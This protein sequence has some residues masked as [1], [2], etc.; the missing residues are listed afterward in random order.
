VFEFRHG[1]DSAEANRMN[2]PSKQAPMCTHPLN[3]PEKVKLKMAK[4]ELSPRGSDVI[5]D[6][7]CGPGRYT[8]KLAGLAHKIVGVDLSVEA[9]RLAKQIC[10]L[11]G[12][13]DR[14]DFVV[15][16]ATKLPFRNASFD[17]IFCIDVLEHILDDKAAL[18]EMNRALKS[19]GKLFLYVPCRN[20]FSFEWFLS[21]IYGIYPKYLGDEESGHVHRYKTNEMVALLGDCGFNKPCIK[22]FAHYI[23]PMLEK[24]LTYMKK[25]FFKSNS[26][27][28]SLSLE[29]PNKFIRWASFFVYL[30]EHTDLLLARL[31]TAGGMFIIVQS[32]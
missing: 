32:G 12:V 7:G 30:L 23:T 29:Y 26:I 17:K 16:D 19:A 25:C 24:A 11:E 5:L 1:L 14:C 8:A 6:L 15:C 27:E 13:S 10:I 3:P 31:P 9:I 4:R 21:K 22:Y 2:V 18:S 20:A 28:A